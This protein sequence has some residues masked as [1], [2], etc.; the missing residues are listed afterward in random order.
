MLFSCQIKTAS[1]NAYHIQTL[2]RP[3]TTQNQHKQYQRIQQHGGLEELL[4]QEDLPQDI[5]GFDDLDS[6][7]KNILSS[8][9]SNSPNRLIIDK[10]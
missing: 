10:M 3:Q 4:D 9:V 2:A 7:S 1:S 8:R 5:V 6:G